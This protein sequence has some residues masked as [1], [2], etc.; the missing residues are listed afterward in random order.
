M[1]RRACLP[2]LAGLLAGCAAGVAPSDSRAPTESTQQVSAQVSPTTAE[3]TS[4]TCEPSGDGTFEAVVLGTSN[5]FGAGRD[6][7]PA[8][9]GGGGG[10]LPPVCELP[11]GSTIV[12]FPSATGEVTPY[13]D[14]PLRNGPAG[15][16]N[17]AGGE[18]TDV[19]SYEG[20]SGIID[21]GNG[22][23]LV[24]VFLSDAVPADPAPERLDFTN[25]EDFEELGPRSPRPSWSATGRADAIS[26]RPERPGCSSASPTP[27]CTRAHPAGTG[28]TPEGWT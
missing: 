18:T 15:D 16:R 3:P 6:T 14:Q 1:S 7:A 28:T 27:S 2:I 21:Q 20:I 12:T 24:G 4:S 13:T 26:C 9:G 23:F 25:A 11:A 8:P 10:T 22:M 17:G 19:T 5:I